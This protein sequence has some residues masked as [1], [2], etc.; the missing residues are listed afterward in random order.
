MKAENGLVIR[1]Y[2]LWSREE[3]RGETS[4]RKARPACVQL[5]MGAR[6]GWPNPALLFPITSQTPMDN[7]IALEIPVIELKRLKLRGPAWIVLSEMNSERDFEH[8]DAIADTMPLGRFS[9]AFT[10]IIRREARS[11]ILRKSYRVV[12]RD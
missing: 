12:Q 3:E 4:G 7:D 2:F 8:S 6:E 10:T 9:P 11:A 1:Y 5:V